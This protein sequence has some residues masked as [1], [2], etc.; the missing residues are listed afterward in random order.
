VGGILHDMGKIVF[1]NI[2]PKLLDR[3]K[4]FCRERNIPQ[5]TFEDL[6]AGM[7][8]AEIGALIAEKWNFPDTLVNIIRYHHDPE[9]APDESLD[10]A[11][12]VYLANMLCEYESGNV[13][14]DQFEE[15]PLAAFGIKGK[16]QLDSLLKQFSFEFGK[17]N[18]KA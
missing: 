10:L 13:S 15:I 6:S 5:A 14:F 8:H 1:S 17:E 2:H 16:E 9:S 4:G 7:N 11:R 3:L 12:S 18:R